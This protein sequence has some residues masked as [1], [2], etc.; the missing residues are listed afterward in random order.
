V[1]REWHRKLIQTVPQADSPLPK[2]HLVAVNPHQLQPVRAPDTPAEVR[3]AMLD[4]GF[5]RHDPEVDLLNIHY[6]S[7]RLPREGLHHAYPGGARPQG[8]AFRLGHIAPFVALRAAAGK[9][10]GFDEDYA[11]IIAGQPRRPAQKRMEAWEA[12]LA[13]C[14]TYDHLDFTFT[15]DDPTGSASGEVPAGLGRELLDGRALRRQLSYAAA[16]ASE[17]DLSRLQPELLLVQQAPPNVGAVAARIGGHAVS[18]VVYRADLRHAEAGFGST[19][20]GGPLSLGGL[21]PG[22]QFEVR[23]LDPQTGR[24][25]DLRTVSASADGGLRLEAPPFAEDVLLQLAPAR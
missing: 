18:L 22:A 8:P 2:R 24:W 19:A 5:Y 11:G 1:V 25:S 23:A 6:I 10:I 4:D 15:T 16:Y 12:L 20:P 21:A 17:L 9:A 3:I 13:G 7:H 14:A